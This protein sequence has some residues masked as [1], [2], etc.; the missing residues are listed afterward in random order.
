MTKRSLLNILIEQFLS[1]NTLFRLVLAFCVAALLV[2]HAEPQSLKYLIRLKGFV[3]AMTYTTLPTF[4]VLQYVHIIN[5]SLNSKYSWEHNLL[6]RILQ[7]IIQC[8]LAPVFIAFVCA[9][10]Y[11]WQHNILVLDTAWFS[12]Y[13]IIIMLLILLL[14][15]YYFGRDLYQLHMTHYKNLKHNLTPGSNQNNKASVANYLTNNN[16]LSHIDVDEI[17][18]IRSIEGIRIAYLNHGGHTE[19]PYPIDNSIQHLPLGRF[20]EINRND[21]VCKENIKEISEVDRIFLLVLK[22]PNELVVKVSQRHSNE[23]R[24]I[25]QHIKNKLKS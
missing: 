13:F 19:W 3:P 17:G 7:Q 23:N 15:L 22:Q 2:M 10:F 16:L 11:Y 4:L 6:P 1:L 24:L 25:F 8:I 14:N 18:F 9:T 5:A 12:Y 21:V 20:L